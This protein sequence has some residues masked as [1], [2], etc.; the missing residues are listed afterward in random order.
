VTGEARVRV[1]LADDHLVVR[2]GLRALLGIRPGVEVV[3]EAADGAEAVRLAAE[4]RPDV[5][6]MDLVMPV[7]DGVS[8]TARIRAGLPGTQ[9]LVLTTYDTDGDIFRA[10]AAGAI[11]YLLKDAGGDELATAIR[12]AARGESVMT[13]SVAARVVGR[14]RAPAEEALS[15]RELEVLG[16][17]AEGAANREIARALHISEATVKSHLLHVYAKLGVSDRTAAVTA[18]LAKGILRLRG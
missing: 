11:G 13:P 9:V 17:A 2:A 5:V 18:A 16:L 12:A 8:A 15:P 7:E 3:G 6:L 14:M 4:L 1:L 10:L